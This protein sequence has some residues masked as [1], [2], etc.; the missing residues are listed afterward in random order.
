MA[1]SENEG[2]DISVGAL[3][4]AESKTADELGG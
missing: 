2:A 4:Y 3:F 1:H